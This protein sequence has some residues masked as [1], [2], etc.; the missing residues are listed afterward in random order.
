MKYNRNDL[1]FDFI[2]I[3]SF[4][5]GM[6]NLNKNDEQINE[7]EKHLAKQDE[8]Y[9]EIIELLKNMRGGN[10]DRKD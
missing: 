10:Y 1:A 3:M 9:E 5:I 6:E 8:Q 4:I 7:L 2:N